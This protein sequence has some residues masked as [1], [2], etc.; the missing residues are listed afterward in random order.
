MGKQL[1]VFFFVPFFF[2][3]FFPR[4]KC[5]FLIKEITN[6]GATIMSKLEVN[7]P[8][9][10]M[11]VELSKSQDV[12]AGDGTTTV[13]VLAGSLLQAS[14]VLLDKGIHPTTIA[15]SFLK[16]AA[17]AEE[18]LNTMAIE[19][20]LKN[21]EELVRIATTSLSSKVVS[22]FSD[23]LAGLA[24][25]AVLRVLDDPATDVNV[26][27]NDIR[28]VKKLGGTVSDTELLEGMALTQK[29][30]NA[31]G[32]P[33]SMKDAH[34][35]LIQYQLSPPKPYMDAKVVIADY[36]QMDR[37]IRE[38]KKYI[39]DVLKKIKAAKCNVLLVQ[40][41]ILRDALTDLSLHFLAKAKILVIKDVERADI[42]FI[43]KTLH[44]RPVAHPDSFSVEHLGH[45]D[46]VETV[47]LGDEKITKFVGI[48]QMG[49]TV[50][51]LVRGSNELVL[52]E[53]ERSIHDALCVVRSLVKSRKMLVGG[54][55][56]E[57]EICLRLQEY[58]RTLSGMEAYCFRAFAA[59]FEIIPYTL[60]ENA[61]LNPIQMVTE[62]R[63]KHAAG[64]V[65]SGINVEA[66]SISDMRVHN[67][68]QPMLVTKSAVRFA[69][70]TVA[71]L[72][73]IDDMV[74]VR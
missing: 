50:T 54:G 49:K 36:T 15:E 11:M 43:C 45:A 60:A 70:E 29:A 48:K 5:F 62:L 46:L 59:A 21:R 13:V 8:A 14:E 26:D 20:D 9:A 53:A 35:G 58:A 69:V 2:V 32:G 71:M 23:K 67:V 30:L 3:S 66:A 61:G 73:K 37:A 55:A 72:L 33:T 16:A 51:I 74:P 65:H 1:R 27:L 38:E 31:A 25:D 68:V 56:A 39:A 17:K 64:L 18:I 42:E 28:V 10:R 40:K 34:I 63:A 24:V 41:S 44:C 52:D 47:S 4:L 19:V 6:D 7:H 57:M 12:E 22:A